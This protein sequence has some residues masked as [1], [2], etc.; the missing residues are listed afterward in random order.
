MINWHQ[1]ISE[2]YLEKLK[3]KIIL[4]KKKSK[5]R[6]YNVPMSFDTETTSFYV[7]TT[8]DKGKVEKV[9]RA[10]MYIW[11]MCIDGVSFYG[12]TWDEFRQ[13]I[14]S[15]KKILGLN[16][17]LRC[18][19]YVHNLAFDFQFMI[20]QVPITKVFARK[21][22][23]PIKALVADSI[24][25]K[26]SY[27]LSGL[28]LANVAKNLKTPIRKMVGDL[29]YSKIRHNQ[30]PLDEKEMK[31]L[32]YDVRIV[33][34]FIKE[35]IEKNNKDISQIPLTKT[36][37]VRKYCRDY[38]KAHTN[39]VSYRQMITREGATNPDLFI[40]LNK[41]F[42]GGYTHA[43]FIYID[44]VLNNVDCVDFAS[45][46]PAVMVCEKYP[47]GKFF[48]M[49]IESKKDFLQMVDR[50]ACVFE[51][52]LANIKS[53][54]VHHIWSKNK[55]VSYSGDIV[56]DNGRIDS[57]KE[58]CTY[59][60]DIDFKIFSLYYEFDIVQ[61]GQ[62]FWAKYDYLPKPLIEC[63]LKYYGDKTLLKGV[64]DMIAEYFVAKGMVNGIYG[65]MVTN[66]LN[67][68]IIFEDEMWEK[69]TPDMETSL[70]NTYVNNPNTFLS[71]QWGVWI[72]A[73]ARYNLLTQLYEIGEDAVYCDT[74]SIKMIHYNKHLETIE[75]YNNEVIEKMKKVCEYYD[76]DFGLTQPEK[77]G[78]K[79]PLGIW[80]FDGHYE[81]FKT[82][83][84]KRYCYS[85]FENGVWDFHITASGIPNV[86]VEEYEDEN[87]EI[88]KRKMK[89]C[90]TAYIAN[91]GDFYFFTDDMEIPASDSRR[92]V[93]TYGDEEYSCLLRD[94]LGNI[95]TVSEKHYVHLEK[96]K[97][98]MGLSEEFASYLYEEEDTELFKCRFKRDEL[99]IT[100][101]QCYTVLV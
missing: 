89:H 40:L 73:H 23:H 42:A 81:Q 88:K 98:K 29:D 71:Y 14:F 97:Y 30:T 86:T 6:Y 50:Y 74:D 94:Y 66:P 67:D 95:S 46:Y 31:Y 13:C 12:R 70:R 47:R 61:V 2:G 62:F 59:M 18:I 8:N 82:L 78:K 43:N 54:T 22:R 15:I 93:H 4:E 21:K 91:H 60:T 68:D 55:C 52:K 9:K 87:G 48:E 25:F 17:Y 63:V 34:L 20:G 16:Q 99:A 35:E 65:M 85:T 37:Y 51:I 80:N 57:A 36:G 32:D 49:K 11:A 44:Q 45:S 33:Y 56:V 3:N 58:I 72:T 24:E 77:D 83:G 101:F 69:N 84:A 28:S 1:Y 100:P 75:N 76:L 90:P 38:I 96:S 64:D 41:A 19:F 39:W 79:Y 10:C 92:L 5:I 27:I 53:K 7:T 26:C